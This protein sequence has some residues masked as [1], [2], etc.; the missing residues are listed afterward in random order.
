[1]LKFLFALLVLAL[2]FGILEPIFSDELIIRMTHSRLF[3]DHGNAFFCLPQCFNE[4]WRISVSEFNIPYNA[5]ESI[6]YNLF[7]SPLIIRIASII[8][9]LLLVFL[10]YRC[11]L[12][13][14]K[15]PVFSRAATIG[16]FAFGMS[17]L[18]FV[19]NRPEQELILVILADILLYFSAIKS[20]KRQ[21]LG[22]GLIYLLGHAVLLFI[23]CTAH[24]N[25]IHFAPLFLFI[26]WN[27]SELR[28]VRLLGILFLT[29]IISD[30]ILFNSLLYSCPN[31]AAIRGFLQS[32]SVSPN[33]ILQNFWQFVEQVILNLR[34]VPFY[35]RNM[36]YSCLYPFNWAPRHRFLAV[37][38]ISNLLSLIA[39]GSLALCALFGLALGIWRVVKRQKL[40]KSTQLSFAL[41]FG[42]L[43]LLSFQ[44][45][46]NW[47]SSVLVVPA[48]V[49]SAI[50]YWEEWSNFVSAR[51]LRV[52]SILVAITASFSLLLYFFTFLVMS[53]P[54]LNTLGEPL[55]LDTIPISANLR[56]SAFRYEQTEEKI[57]A[58][59]ALCGFS[60][61]KIYNRLGVDD[62]TYW[63]LRKS[64]D[65]IPIYYLNRGYGVSTHTEL[66]ASSIGSLEKFLK[67]RRSDGIITRCAEI[68]EPELRKSAHQLGDFCC[69]NFQH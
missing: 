56:F 37:H 14:T 65:P 25:V 69:W 52:W 4:K 21:Q 22:S 66:Y 17:P 59:A 13:I 1:M 61:D 33:L 18:L 30:T 42:L 36:G 46:K 15:H 2:S 28:A 58:A 7:S 9:A 20:S 43:L 23:A 48:I 34:A 38:Q 32:M 27:L 16:V 47:Y 51:W 62:L 64:V 55:F 6:F 3:Y 10:F 67:D 50:L 63:A 35:F 49:V 26:G 41:C 11:A 68:V 39:L 31:D 5:F 8:K 57:W 29:L 12:R 44:I 40:S 24:P 45:G 54:R 60:K 53:P 19:L